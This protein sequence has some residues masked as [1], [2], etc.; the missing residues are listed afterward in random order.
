[1]EDLPATKFRYQEKPQILFVTL[2]KDLG[3]LSYLT[4]NLLKHYI[5]GHNFS[6][7][8]VILAVR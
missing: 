8:K 6:S 3:L 5:Y 2:S 7:S 4:Q 1:M